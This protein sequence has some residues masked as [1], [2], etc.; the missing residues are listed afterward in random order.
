MISVTIFS[1]VASTF[2]A[3]SALSAALS[4]AVL[5]LP[6]FAKEYLARALFGV[7]GSEGAAVTVIEYS[8][9]IS[10]P[11]AVAK[12]LVVPALTPVTIPVAETVATSSFSELQTTFW[13]APAGATTAVN[14]NVLVAWTSVASPTAV[15]VTPVAVGTAA[16]VNSISLGLQR[17][18]VSSAYHVPESF[19]TLE[20]TFNVATFSFNASA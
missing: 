2:V 7:T 8:P 6:L 1:V 10:V 5:L 16:G 15:M 12:I 17:L 13:L 9:L 14:C 11:S 4:Y 19:V 18:M 20:P 3:K